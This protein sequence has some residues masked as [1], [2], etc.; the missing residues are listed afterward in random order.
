MAETKRILAAPG[1]R[2]AV[3][4]AAGKQQR[5][6]RGA[7]C[8]TEEGLLDEVTKTTL[9]GPVVVEWSDFYAKAERNKEIVLFPD[10]PAP[11]EQPA[12]RK[13]TRAGSDR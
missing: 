13:A 3:V 6:Q 5:S 8:I 10:A 4:S 7:L 2:V 1:L 12:A 9:P 11:V